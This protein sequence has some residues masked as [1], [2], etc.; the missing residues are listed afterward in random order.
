MFFCL[1]CFLITCV[2]SW[3]VEFKSL[4]EREHF[5]KKNMIVKESGIVRIEDHYLSVCVVNLE[6]LQNFTQTLVL[7]KPE[8]V[9][10]IVIP[11]SKIEIGA[12]PF[13]YH[14]TSQK[15]SQLR[16][17]AES[18]SDTSNFSEEILNPIL[19]PSNGSHYE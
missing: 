6:L 1:K 3:T 14:I 19:Q 2:F 4:K 18:N 17:L 7:S 12:L 5:L 8:P 13:I 11:F 15:Y 16:K 9:V 10:L